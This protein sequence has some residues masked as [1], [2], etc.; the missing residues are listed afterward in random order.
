LPG[1]VLMPF[2]YGVLLYGTR[3]LVMT[4]ALSSD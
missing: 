3:Y 2:L 4:L 1:P